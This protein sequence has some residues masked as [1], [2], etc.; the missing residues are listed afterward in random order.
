MKKLHGVM[1]S[2]YVDLN[3]PVQSPAKDYVAPVLFISQRYSRG[4]VWPLDFIWHDIERL[5]CPIHRTSGPLGAFRECFLELGRVTLRVFFRAM[6]AD[7]FEPVANVK[8]EPITTDFMI[9]NCIV[10]FKS[11]EFYN[12]P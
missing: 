9:L 2:R 1:V 6:Y 7:E 10:H 8:D 4:P 3:R 5:C 12:N 11:P